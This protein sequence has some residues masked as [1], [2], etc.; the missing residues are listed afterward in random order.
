MVNIQEKVYACSTVF[1][2]R[3][4]FV[5]EESKSKEHGEINKSKIYIQSEIF[6]NGCRIG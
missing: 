6:K 5:G 1:V 3:N 4:T 2:E